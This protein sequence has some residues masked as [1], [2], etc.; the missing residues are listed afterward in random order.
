MSVSPLGR[1]ALE[2]QRVDN[3]RTELENYQARDEWV[4]TQ[5]AQVQ[6]EERKS[7]TPFERACT[8]GGLQGFPK[9]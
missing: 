2:N 9:V 6:K 7:L 5:E 1:L 4:Q 8:L 3:L